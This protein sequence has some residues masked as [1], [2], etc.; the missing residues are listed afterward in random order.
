[1]RLAII[2]NNDG[3][4]RLAGAARAGGH[5]VVFIGLQKPD[6]PDEA[7]ALRLLAPLDFDLLVNCFA[8]FRYRELHHRYPTVNV[9]LAPLPAYRGRHP[10]QW[11]LI[12]GEETFG[13]TIHDIND[14][15]DDG[16][17]RWQATIEVA[18][19]WSNPPAPRGTIAKRRGGF[20]RLPGS[21]QPS[22]PGPTQ[23]P[24]AGDLRHASIPHR[25]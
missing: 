1:M 20:C 22:P 21:L 24:G 14:D 18:D 6:I 16:A 2:G 4:A 12:N 5:E 8:N 11:A 13:V 17:I 19:G 25:Q 15:F 7:T 3:P 10:L 23:R 9:H